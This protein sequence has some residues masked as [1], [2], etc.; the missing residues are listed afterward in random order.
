MLNFYHPNELKSR[1]SLDIGAQPLPLHRTIDDCQ[2]AF[3][4]SV[5]AGKF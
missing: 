5:R 2:A 3:D 4:Y 1:I